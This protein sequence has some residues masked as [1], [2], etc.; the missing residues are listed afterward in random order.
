GL[1]SSTAASPTQVVVS[2]VLGETAADGTWYVKKI[3]NNSFALYS[4][5]ALTTAV[6]GTAAYL[7]G[8][9]WVA[10]NAIAASP[11]G[12]VAPGGGNNI[13][14]TPN[15]ITTGLANGMMVTITGD[16]LAA[17]NGTF[18]IS[19]VTVGGGKTT[20]QLVGTGSTPAGT[21]GGGT[22]TEVSGLAVG[23]ANP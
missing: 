23:P 1:S 6:N 11:T 18:I 21:G 7:G 4:D 3:D 12:A 2:G 17:A 5:A 19:N 10:T 15:S 20:F 9:T 16:S 13:V 22:W 14:I 8:G